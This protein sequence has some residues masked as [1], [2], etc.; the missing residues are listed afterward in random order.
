MRPDVV[1]VIPDCREGNRGG[2]PGFRTVMGTLGD[3]R[4]AFLHH[5]GKFPGF[6]LPAGQRLRAPQVDFRRVGVPV[7]KRNRRR[8]ARQLRR[9]FAVLI[10]L[11][12]HL[13]CVA[14]GAGL[15]HVR[16]VRPRFRNRIDMLA[17]IILGV[18]DL[19]ETDGSGCSLVCVCVADGLDLF[20]TFHHHKGELVLIHVPAGEG[21]GSFQEDFRR[22]LI[23]VGEFHGV[24]IFQHFC[25]QFAV[26]VR[27][28]FDRHGK[29][30]CAGLGHICLRR[31]NL[32]HRIGVF[33][34][35][36]LGI[37]DL[38]K[39]NR[40][41]FP[42]L[43]PDVLACGNR[44][45]AF[46]HHKV[47]F[48]G[49]HGASGQRLRPV[50]LQFRIVLVFVCKFNL[51]RVH[52]QFRCQ[53]IGRFIRVHVHL[54]DIADRARLR[55]VPG[56]RH[57]FGHRIGMLA[58]VVLVVPDR[59]KCDGSLFSG[60]RRAVLPGHNL[61]AVFRHNESELPGCHGTAGQGLGAF[62]R[63][64]G[65][66]RVLVR[67]G[68]LVRIVLHDFRL[69]FA[70]LVNIYVDL[71]GEACLFA[72]LRHIFRPWRV[73]GHRIGMQSDLRLV[74]FNFAEGNRSGR[75]LAGRR[76]GA[77]GDG[78]IVLLHREAELF[79]L[80]VAAAQGLGAGQ[81]DFRL[82][83]IGV[84]KSHIRGI[85]RD[86]CHQIPIGPDGYVDLH[87]EAGF[88][89]LGHVGLLRRHFGDRIGMLADVILGI[90]DRGKCNVPG[91]SVVGC[92][93]G[94]GG[95]LLPV[96][97]SDEAELSGCHIAAGQGLRA[98]QRDSRF[99]LVLVGERNRFGFALH[100][101][102]LQA[103]V[104]VRIYV[105]LD[106]EALRA[107][108][109]H[110]PRHRRIFRHCIGVHADAVLGIWD[111]RKCNRSGRVLAGSR[112]GTGGNSCP[113]FLHG[114]VELPGL[115]IAA[116]QRLRAFRRDRRRG[117]I[118]VRER[119]LLIRVHQRCSQL[120][121]LVDADLHLNGVARRPGLGHMP[122]RR[123]FRHGV[124][125][126][127]H[128]FLGIFNFA[129][130][131]RPGGSLACRRVG[132]GGNF[133]VVFVFHHKGEFPGFHVAAR[134]GLGAFQ[135]DFG[136]VVILVD[137]RDS[138]RISRL[139]GLQVSI[140]VDI[141]FH[142]HGETRL[143]GLAD[144]SAG[145]GFR[146]SI[147]MDAH[148]VLVIPDFAKRNR[149]GFS[150]A[151][152]RVGA[153]CGGGRPFRNGKAEL[154]GRHIA[155]VQRF[156]AVQRDPGRIRIGVFDCG[157]AGG[158]IRAVCVAGGLRG[159]RLNHIVFQP[160]DGSVFVPVILRQR[161]PVVL[162]S[163]GPVQ[164]NRIADQRIAAFFNPAHNLVQLLQVILD[165]DRRGCAAEADVGYAARGD[166]HVR[167]EQVPDQAGSRCLG[168][169]RSDHR[170]QAPRGFNPDGMFPGRAECKVDGVRIVVVGV[171]RPGLPALSVGRPVVGGEAPS[172]YGHRHGNRLADPE[173]LRPVNLHIIV[174]AGALLENPKGNLLVFRYAF[175]V[176]SGVPG[177]IPGL[178]GL[179][180]VG[181][182]AGVFSVLPGDAGG[183]GIIRA[184]PQSL[185][186]AGPVRSAAVERNGL[187][188][189][190]AAGVGRRNGYGN[191]LRD[192]V[193]ADG[194]RDFRRKR[195][196][197]PAE[198]QLV[199]VAVGNG[200]ALGL[201]GCPG[202]SVPVCHR[203]GIPGSGGHAVQVSGPV[204]AAVQHHP[205]SVV[206]SRG[207]APGRHFPI[208]PV[209]PDLHVLL[210]RKVGGF[211][212]HVLHS[213]RNGHRG[214]RRR[215]GHIV[216]GYLR[217]QGLSAGRNVVKGGSPAVARVQCPGNAG[218][219]YLNTGA[220]RKVVRPLHAHRQFPGLHRR[221]DFLFLHGDQLDCRRSGVVGHR[222]S[223]PVHPGL[224]DA[225]GR[226]A[227]VKIGEGGAA[228]VRRLGGFQPVGCRIQGHFHGH[229]L[230]ADHVSGIIRLGNRV[231]VGLPGVRNRVFNCPEVNRHNPP[232]CVR[233]QHY[234]RDF[235]H[236][237]IRVRRIIR[238]RR[239]YG[240]VPFVAVR[241]F[242]PFA[243]NL[244]RGFQVG[245]GPPVR[246]GEFSVLLRRVTVIC[247]NGFCIE[248]GHRNSH[249]HGRI[250]ILHPV[251][252]VAA[253]LLVIRV[254]LVQQLVP[255][256]GIDR[257]GAAR[258]DLLDEVV[259]CS[260]LAVFDG[261]EARF[262]AGRLLHRHGLC[263][264]PVGRCAYG[265]GIFAVGGVA[266][267]HRVCR[268]GRIQPAGRLLQH[269]GEF[270][271]ISPLVD[272]LLR[273][274]V[275]GLRVPCLI[276]EGDGA[277][278]IRVV[279]RVDHTLEPGCGRRSADIVVPEPFHGMS[280]VC[281]IFRERGIYSV[282]VPHLYN[283]HIVFLFIVEIVP[284]CAAGFSFFL[285]PEYPSVS[286]FE[287]IVHGLAVVADRVH[288]GPVAVPRVVVGVLVPSV[289]VKLEHF[290]GRRSPVVQLLSEGCVRVRHLRQVLVPVVPFVGLG[291]AGHCAAGD[292][293][294]FAGLGN[295]G[296]GIRP[297]NQEH[298]DRFVQLH[299][300]RVR[301]V[302]YRILGNAFPSRVAGPGYAVRKGIL[303]L[304][305]LHILIRNV[306]DYGLARVH[307]DVQPAAGSV[308]NR[309]DSGRVNID[310]LS[311]RELC[312]VNVRGAR[313][314]GR[315][316]RFQAVGH[317]LA[318]VQDRVHNG[319]GYFALRGLNK[320]GMRGVMVHL[321]RVRLVDKQHHIP[322]GV[323]V[324]F[325]FDLRRGNRAGVVA[326]VRVH[327]HL[328]PRAAPVQ[329]R[330]KVGL[331]VADLV[332]HSGGNAVVDAR[333]EDLRWLQR[334][335]Q[336]IAG[337]RQLMLNAG[338]V[339]AAVRR[340]FLV[341]GEG[342]VADC[343]GFRIGGRIRAVR[344][345]GNR[346]PGVLADHRRG[347]ILP[348]GGER[349]SVAPLFIQVD[350]CGDIS[351]GLELNRLVILPGSVQGGG[352]QQQ[353]IIFSGDGHRAVRRVEMDHHF[354]A[355]RLFLP[356]TDLVVHRAVRHRAVSGIRG[357]A[358]KAAVDGRVIYGHLVASRP[359]PQVAECLDLPCGMDQADLDPALYFGRQ[360]LVGRSD[361]VAGIRA[362]VLIDHIAESGN[363]NN[364]RGR[365]SVK[366]AQLFN[367]PVSIARKCGNVVRREIA[368]LAHVQRNQVVIAVHRRRR[369]SVAVLVAECDPDV[370][371]SFFRDHQ[372]A[373]SV[374]F[375][376]PYICGA[377]VRLSFGPV[378][379]FENGCPFIVIVVF[380]FCDFN[381]I[382]RP[383][384]GSGIAVISV[385]PRFE[386]LE[387]FKAIGRNL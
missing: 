35:I 20:L 146:H 93:V 166:Q 223:V 131:N 49:L 163:V 353:V 16:L 91:V 323:H 169:R 251:Q 107:G 205:G 214:A 114:E 272:D 357:I 268:H 191:I 207:N 307:F 150:L 181:V 54:H 159:R 122:A 100:D 160:V 219:R 40:R 284:V 334:V 292:H 302:E 112:V 36:R 328:V 120:V 220:V 237:D 352:L 17:D 365:R 75:V 164:L 119:N 162:P 308:E 176:M 69:Q 315:F 197:V 225:G 329:V 269:K 241:K 190:S 321:V 110:V 209:D 61:L 240:K 111:C 248:A 97:R 276:P 350:G 85:L 139:P 161:S 140:R 65:G 7:F 222:V 263:K 309:R 267:V 359:L 382:Y 229:L 34:D 89:R 264:R 295:R 285:N 56:Q 53:L 67:K 98:F 82:V 194:N 19:L 345:G 385:D 374:A 320:D 167:S 174:L 199:V 260:G 336:R 63:N 306:E 130:C 274:Q 124:G 310:G 231:Y 8:I 201:A 76:V 2:V 381:V 52:C 153:V 261:P 243:F 33:T 210:R 363:G 373:V 242:E 279:G 32:C 137:K 325:A 262:H 173:F 152:G 252:V 313:R 145:R 221:G 314:V 259:V 155:A 289:N 22:V 42:G 183:N 294:A 95:G 142:L 377:S 339:A 312:Q 12:V 103:A 218:H 215:N 3:Y 30:G 362:V 346:R 121:L 288:P 27:R 13:H 18:M 118:R 383:A 39:F 358:G 266:S 117:L 319:F 254:C 68:D 203:N 361:R 133:C 236:R 283:R 88:A 37:A 344:S 335:F 44:L 129:E 212:R 138:L 175:F 101:F 318:V 25:L 70:L 376:F 216:A 123:G 232:V 247:H 184:F 298:T 234:G 379:L 340:F 135:R 265:L 386:S 106:R 78:C 343:K 47:E 31:R 196:V 217:S 116:R 245:P 290:A 26:G 299:V 29:A 77:G 256:V 64:L 126:G 48:P 198:H 168:R 79:V 60:C 316:L 255:V 23:F 9:Q 165:G 281:V 280:R 149:P 109:L 278:G 293:P 368:A 324:H 104:G 73:L 238:V 297:G 143:P 45:G 387:Y 38:I 180:A 202:H 127:A 301:H 322:L 370:K 1:L 206:R 291:P 326:Q 83:G 258:D 356:E 96:L 249:R 158:G 331:H 148:I 171:L 156:G 213:V 204:V 59:V 246:V 132:A 257:T 355:D 347:N 341:I 211:Q 4:V 81:R 348:V 305:D 74:I 15:F 80:H 179:R 57:L 170:G 208:A 380:Q 5:K 6:H 364:S 327:V 92:R 277:D 330:G 366:S 43:C 250:V 188:V 99:S 113:A 24:R 332:K 273:L 270:G 375:E 141:D 71:H 271:L 226:A 58:D 10:H 275:G 102:G 239:G 304:A 186:F 189:I 228:F 28:H 154:P 369:N 84:F 349:L 134:Q 177:R 46:L 338:Q 372:V 115:H 224:F 14:G 94:A 50:Q 371:R 192:I 136:P 384:A 144:L 244:L 87:F 303:N 147:G 337:Q 333:S 128:I 378:N 21:F 55:H 108:L 90:G 235:R 11:H 193:P 66:V 233:L 286:V 182:Q 351:V 157:Q 62:Q 296:F 41:F 360:V 172:V 354:V 195:I 185:E 151:G 178:H 105:H 227:R 253:V 51:R 342:I 282:V 187:C 367:I 200:D 317:R 230:R 287:R 86:L 311:V 72:R 125:M 300:L